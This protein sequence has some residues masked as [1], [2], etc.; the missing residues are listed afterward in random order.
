MCS[1]PESFAGGG[2]V[3]PTPCTLSPKQVE[4]GGETPRSGGDPLPCLNSHKCNEDHVWNPSEAIE[5]EAVKAWNKL[6]GSHRKTAYALTVNVAAFGKRVGV[7]KVGFLT[8]TFA[9]H[10]TDN[11]EASR[12]WKSLRTGV[13]K[14][15][16]P[17]GWV[18]VRERQRSGRLHFH[19]LVACREDI[20]TGAD[21]EAFAR[22]DWSSGNRALREEWAFW[23]ETAVEYGFGRTEL[24][25]LKSTLE[26]ISKYVGKYISKNIE[27]RQEADQGARLVMYAQGLDHLKPNAFAWNSPRAWLWRKRVAKVAARCGFTGPEQFKE[28]FG[29]TWA[30][31]LATWVMAEELGVKEDGDLVVRRY[32]SPAHADADGGVTSELM[33]DADPRAPVTVTACKN[34]AYWEANCGEWLVEMRKGFAFGRIQ[35]SQG[36]YDRLSRLR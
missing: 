16:Y 2:V 24:L 15:R 4:G 28:Y 13:L 25:P 19:V 7:E 26:G 6:N 1:G 5:E 11:K 10:V 14:Q 32:P 17:G 23:R 27:G 35:R 36:V 18:A 20:R 34:E 30:W 3:D 21:F 29:Q 22:K 9:D 33:D 12:R 8:L 31:H